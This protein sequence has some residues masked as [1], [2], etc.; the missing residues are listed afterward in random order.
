MSYMSILRCSIVPTDVNVGLGVSMFSTA[1]TDLRDQTLLWLYLA[2]VV[3]SVVLACVLFV[4]FTGEAVIFK[5]D[6][7]FNTCPPP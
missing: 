2:F 1:R 7:E 6:G 5:V 4:V 3:F